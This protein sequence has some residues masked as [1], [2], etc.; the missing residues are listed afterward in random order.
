MSNI[1]II[2][3]KSNCVPYSYEKEHLH[4]IDIDTTDYEFDQLTVSTFNKIYD[5]A[6][7]YHITVT[8]WDALNDILD[9][10]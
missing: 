2:V 5:W 10:I 3:E 6:R 9:D 1:R 8:A 4:Y 7:K